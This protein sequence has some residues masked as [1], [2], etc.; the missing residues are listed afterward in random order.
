ML[1]CHTS[2]FISAPKKIRVASRRWIF[3]SLLPGIKSLSPGT[4]GEK[5]PEVGMGDP[6]GRDKRTIRRSI[7]SRAFSSSRLVFQLIP[8]NSILDKIVYRIESVF[9]RV[10]SL[11]WNLLSVIFFFP[12][13]INSFSVEDNWWRNFW[14][15]FRKNLCSRN[16]NS[17][18][19]TAIYLS[20]F[21]SFEWIVTNF[22]NFETKFPR[23][24]LFKDLSFVHNRF[25]KVSEFLLKIS[26]LTNFFSQKRGILRYCYFLHFPPPV[27]ESWNFYEFQESN[28]VFV[29]VFQGKRKEKKNICT[30]ELRENIFTFGY[31]YLFEER[32]R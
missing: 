5:G 4:R 14:G 13:C 7:S 23:R 24:E 12:A 18:F 17:I 30:I 28:E 27:F 26:N 11:S 6:L 10:L 25:R 32:T 3:F 20:S 16:S 2:D 31:N 15:S 22:W 19:I 21:S 8:R 1:A 9:L 29:F